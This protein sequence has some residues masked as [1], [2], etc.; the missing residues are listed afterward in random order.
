MLDVLALA[1][2]AF[3]VLLALVMVWGLDQAGHAG[4]PWQ[5]WFALGL[6]I[7][8][9]ATVYA[10][11]RV[12]DDGD[13]AWLVVTA[14]P[15]LAMLVLLVL[16]RDTLWGNFPPSPPV[17]WLQRVGIVVVFALPG[18]LAAAAAS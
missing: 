5:S 7:V 11:L 3:T 6:L 16:D 10:V 15:P 8:M 2:T 4:A 12:L 14:L 9:A 18:L 1:A 17:R 13:P